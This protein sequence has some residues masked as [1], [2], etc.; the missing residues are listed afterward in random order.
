[1]R[2]SRTNVLGVGIDCVT[3][4]EA[5][6]R[7]RGFL[8]GNIQRHVTTPNNEMLVEACRNEMFLAVLRMADLAIPDSTGIAWACRRAG[9]AGARRVPGVDAMTALCRGLEAR[10]G[11][12]LLGAAPGVAERAAAA[13]KAMNPQ[14]RIAGTHA[15]S[16]RPEDADAIVAM[17]NEAQPSLLL[18]AYGAPAQDLWIARHLADMPSVK[19][20]AG[21]GGTLDF[22][23]G[24]AKR[25]PAFMRSAGLEWLWRLLRQPS[26]LPRIWRA[27]V[28]FPLL[29]L[30][31]KE[32]AAS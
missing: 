24:A 6:T 31:A 20:A 28:V 18:V 25:A 14:L 22:L 23:A 3:L 8:D 21:V 4:E 13:L 12:F 7:M 17:I 29:V 27:V 11:V 1:M 26:R 2:V 16:P 5:V 9:A 15:G 30:T 10:C 19:L 32:H